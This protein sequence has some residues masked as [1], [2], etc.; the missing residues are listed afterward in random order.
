MAAGYTAGE[1][2]DIIWDL[3]FAQLMD[4]GWEDRLAAV[5]LAP[6][7]LIPRIG[8]VIPH[9]P[10]V[11]KDFGVYEGDRFQELAE[12]LLAQ[13]GKRVYGDLLVPGQ[14]H[15]PQYRYRLRVIA[16]DLTA[17]RMLVLP[18]DI[19]E[20]GMDP[21]ELSIALS[22]RMSMSI[23]LFFEPVRLKNPNTGLTHIIVDGGVLSN[24]PI[25]LFDAP[26]GQPVEWPTLGFNLYQPAPGADGPPD[27][28]YRTPRQVN[29]PV[30]LVLALQ[31]IQFSAIDRRYVSKR[32]W[33]RTI[34]I[35]SVGVKSTDFGLTDQQK[36][37]LLESGRSAARSFLS[38]FD[39]EAYKHAWRSGP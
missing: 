36:Q 14:E 10:S 13:K 6:A 18:D 21:D 2:R 9:I 32:H 28:F 19:S 16:S 15:N 12:H 8:H 23:P 20:F 17:G 37:A 27:P 30:D 3:D 5:V 35:S 1:V 31:S 38:A 26:P 39:F 33:A 7:R 11:V 22:L 34:P 25:W 24:Y 29:N 4:K